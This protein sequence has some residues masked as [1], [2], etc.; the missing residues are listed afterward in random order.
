MEYEYQ[1]SRYVDTKIRN[2]KIKEKCNYSFSIEHNRINY[3]CYGY[4]RLLKIEYRYQSLSKNIYA[5]LSLICV[6]A[7]C[8]SIRENNFDIKG[9]SRR[10]QAR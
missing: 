7:S 4:H 5:S 10:S 2:N 9:V 8:N 1:L 3:D 6:I